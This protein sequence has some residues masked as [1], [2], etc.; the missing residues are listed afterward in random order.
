ME[1]MEKLADASPRKP[2]LL[3]DAPGGGAKFSLEFPV[4]SSEEESPNIEISEQRS[5]ES[6]AVVATAI[7]RPNGSSGLADLCPQPPLKTWE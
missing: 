7:L 3:A 4:F 6:S 2:L 1:T 5:R